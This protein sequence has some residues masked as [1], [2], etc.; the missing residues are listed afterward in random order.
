MDS[1]IEVPRH[2]RRFV[3]RIGS[4]VI[5][6]LA[7][8]GFAGVVAQAQE[9]VTTNRATEVRANPDDAAASLQSLAAQAKVQVIERKGAWSKVKTETQTGWVRMMHLRGGVTLE[10]APQ[11]GSKSSGGGFLAGFNRLLGGNQQTSQRAQSA[12]VGIR[13]LSAEELK[14]ASPN[15]QA[16]ADMKSFV[17]NKPDAEKFAR[18]VNLAK[19]DVADPGEAPRGGRR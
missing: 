14:T 10:E 5:A 3:Y 16:L 1:L 9:S 2:R 7:L 13:G 17:C 11:S 19:V 8:T 6:A 12:T 18:E 15:P 4:A